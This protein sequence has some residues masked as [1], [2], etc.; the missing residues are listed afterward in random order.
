MAVILKSMGFME[1]NSPLEVNYFENAERRQISSLLM[2]IGLHIC[3]LDY[4]PKFFT[5]KNV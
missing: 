4:L 5:F 2:E 1:G 3:F